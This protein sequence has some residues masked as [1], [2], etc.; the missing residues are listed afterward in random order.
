MAR[1]APGGPGTMVRM[2]AALGPGEWVDDVTPA[3]WIAP[4]LHPFNQ[5]T[6]SVIPEGF[7]AYCRV[8]HPLDGVGRWSDLAARNGR[9]AHSQMQLH[10]I[11]VSRG[12]GI[13]AFDG[14]MDG[15]VSWGS[16]PV[17]E[18]A[19][20]VEDL[21]THT[22]TPDRCWFAAWEGWGGLDDGGVTELVQL[23]GR[24]YLLASGA[25]D[26]ATDSV[27]E[28]PFD[29]S[30][31]LWWPDDLAWCVATEVDFAWTYVGGTGAAIDALLADARLEALP[32]LL[33]DLPF[34]NADTVNM[35]LD[36]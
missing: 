7:E 28:P 33:T 36:D 21:R 26:A 32:T 3:D 22:T 1:L 2:S 25:I 27:L 19:A 8:F 29:Q 31:S 9:I 12:E 35:A 18:R 5:D 10:A 34:A 6:G 16:L 11:S 14:R 4:R 23:P 13:P 24:G 15:R 17:T 30:L 20:V